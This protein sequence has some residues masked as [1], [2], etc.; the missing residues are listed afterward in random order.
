M[1]CS[2]LKREANPLATTISNTTLSAII[3]FQSQP[4]SQPSGHHQ[5]PYRPLF[6]NKV[7]TLAQH[8]TP[9]PNPTTTPALTL[10]LCPN[11]NRKANPLATNKAGTPTSP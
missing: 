5:T 3:M 2:N 7:P 10:L 11:L 9:F 8:P 6:E 4:R 1:Q